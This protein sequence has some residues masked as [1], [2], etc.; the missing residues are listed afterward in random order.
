MR[1]PGVA[2][3]DQ[4]NTARHARSHLADNARRFL[5]QAEYQTE[6][7]EQMLQETN[8]PSHDAGPIHTIMFGEEDLRMRS[9]LGALAGCSIGESL[10]CWSRTS[11]LARQALLSLTLSCRRSRSQL[12]T[13]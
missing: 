2:P 1:L 5:K 13:T 12:I 8:L 3:Q 11:P 6:W 4:H 9:S 7:E 10:L